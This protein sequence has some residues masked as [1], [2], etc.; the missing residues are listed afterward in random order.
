MLKDFHLLKYTAFLELQNSILNII[1]IYCN[2]GKEYT[3]YG[4]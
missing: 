3:I 1:I 2:N 4:Q